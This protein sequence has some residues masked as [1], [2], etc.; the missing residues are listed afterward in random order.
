LRMVRPEDTS[1]PRASDGSHMN[2]SGYINPEFA[3]AHGPWTPPGRDRFQDLVK[4]Q[5]YNDINHVK[6]PKLLVFQDKMAMGHSVEV[7]VPMLDHVLY[8]KLFSIPTQYHLRN[9]ST[10]AILEASEDVH[11]HSPARMAEIRTG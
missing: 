3:R 4:S 2:E 8:Q 7:R 9:G 10:K 6:M 11:A 1:T 5:V